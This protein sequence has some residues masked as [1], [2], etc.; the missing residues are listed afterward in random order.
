MW[1]VLLFTPWVY[2]VLNVKGINYLDDVF[3]HMLQV[4][5]KREWLLGDP[6]KSIAY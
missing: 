4:S 2:M 3:P 6:I 1:T 5:W